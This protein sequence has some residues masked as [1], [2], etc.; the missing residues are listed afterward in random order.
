MDLLNRRPSKMF[1]G[2][3]IILSELLGNP[4]PIVNASGSD[5]LA[6]F[7]AIYLVSII[8]YITQCFLHILI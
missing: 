4:S 7:T 3:K 2:I 1:N 5:S 6:Y 8:L